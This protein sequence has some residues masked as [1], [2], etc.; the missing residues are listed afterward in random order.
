MPAN[1]V[2]LWLIRHGETEWSISGAHTSRTDIPL[3]ERGKERAKAIHDYLQCRE[4]ALVLTS[5]RQ[6]ARETC[7]IAGYEKVAQVE[8]NL[9]EWD[10]GEL[11][12]LTTAQIR[13]KLPNWSVWSGDLPGGENCAQVRARAQ[14]V[15]DRCV[16][17][18]G[19]IALFSHGHFLRVL[20]ACWLG[21]PTDA[22]RYFAL[23]TGAVSTLSFEHENRVIATWN[24]SFEVD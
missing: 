12:G 24:R 7:R 9:Q 17:T 16:Q 4:F 3:T 15:I 6:R 19:R 20:A 8:D 18:G 11:E 21:L 13:E 10:Y 23:G 1:K 22:G 14:A 2:E 5:P